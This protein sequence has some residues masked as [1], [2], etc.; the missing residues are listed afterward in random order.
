MEKR[1]QA[2]K[3]IKLTETCTKKKHKI[4]LPKFILAD[5]TR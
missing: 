4:N 2:N 3:K 5:C 1:R